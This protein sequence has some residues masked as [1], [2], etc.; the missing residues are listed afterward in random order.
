MHNS[1]CQYSAPS[2]LLTVREVA[3]VLKLSERTVRTRLAEGSLRCVRLTR[4]CVRV[5]RS[6]L[7][8]FIDG[9]RS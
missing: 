2:D 6:D 9:A 5:R 7:N 4:R 3:A 8:K 1:T